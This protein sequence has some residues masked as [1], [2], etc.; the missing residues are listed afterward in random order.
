MG[1]APVPAPADLALRGAGEGQ[2]QAL[3]QN[4]DKSGSV[5]WGGTVHDEESSVSRVR[6]AEE[7]S[8]PP[9]H[10]LPYFCFPFASLSAFSLLAASYFSVFPL[11]LPHSNS[12]ISPCT[13]SPIYSFPFS[14][15]HLSSLV[16]IKQRWREA[17]ARP[18]ASSAASGRGLSA[19]PTATPSSV[20]PK[21]PR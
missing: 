12:L 15:T 2:A 3:L 7:A 8:T 21:S 20:P 1:R 17:T 11:F 19:C 10:C 6:A 9:A 4:R 18:V 16:S 14:N 5:P 13:S